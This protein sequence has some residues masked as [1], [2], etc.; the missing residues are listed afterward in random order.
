M[1]TQILINSLCADPESFVRGGGGGRVQ[2]KSAVFCVLLVDEGRED[3]ITTKSWLSFIE[4]AFHRQADDS[5]TLNAGLVD[6]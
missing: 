4:M 3:P 5:P 2:L 6:L 1:L